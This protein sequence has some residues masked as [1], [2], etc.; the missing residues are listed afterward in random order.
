MLQDIRLYI[1]NNQVD[2]IEEIS[3]PFTYQLTDLDNPTIVKNSFSKT[4]TIE[5]TKN[6]NRIFGEIYNFDRE[7]M[8]DDVLLTGVY[9]NPSYRTPF[10]LYKDGEIIEQGYMQ[11][12]DVVIKNKT[13]QYN[14]TLYGGLGDFFYNLSYNEDN[15]PLQLKDLDY[16]QDLTFIID[17]KI[18]KKC[19]E[20]VGEDTNEITDVIQFIPC[21]NGVYDDF[22]NDKVLINTKDTDLFP[23]VKNVDDETYMVKSGYAMGE[24]N[25]EYTEWE[26]KNLVS[27]KQRPALRLKSFI[28]ACCSPVNNGGYDVELDRDFFNESNPYFNKTYIALPMLSELIESNGEVIEDKLNGG[29][30]FVGNKNG[31]ITNYGFSILRPNELDVNDFGVVNMV[32]YPINTLIDVAV[33]FQL[34]FKS[35]DNYKGILYNSG[36]YEYYQKEYYSSLLVQLE[37]VDT[38]TLE[39][40]GRSNWLNFTN[41]LLGGTFYSQPK[42]WKNWNNAN[43]MPMQTIFGEWVYSS[44]VDK[45]YFKS[46]TGNTFKIKLEKCSK[47]DNIKFQLKLEW[48]SNQNNLSPILLEKTYYNYDLSPVYNGYVALAIDS[49]TSTISI[50]SG[51]IVVAT[52]KKITQDML[53]KTEKTP[54]DYLLSY[55][56]MFGLYVYKENGENKIYIKKRNNYFNNKIVDINERIDWGNEVRINPILFDKKFYKLSLESNDSYYTEKYKTNYGVEYGQKRINTNYNFNNDTTDMLE[57]NV[58]QNVISCVDNSIYYRTFYNA[59]NKE[60][61]VFFADGYSLKLFSDENDTTID[62]PSGT[63]I[64]LDKTVDWNKKSGYDFK[65]GLCCFSKGEVKELADIESSLVFYCGKTKAKDINNNDINYWLSDDLQE[66][67]DLNESPCYLYTNTEFDSNNKWIAYKLNEIPLF[68]KY[69]IKDNTVVD[70]WDFGKPKELFIPDVNYSED[71]TIYNKYWKAMY[72]DMLNINTKLVT[73]YVNFKGMVVNNQLLKDFYYFNNSYWLLNKIENFDICSNQPVKCEFIKINDV[74]NY[75]VDLGDKYEY[76]YSS[77]N[78]I[79]LPYSKGKAKILI[80]STTKW[81]IM[82]YDN[83]IYDVYPATGDTGATL[84]TIEYKDNP[85][86]YSENQFQ[87]TLGTENN[88]NNILQINFIQ[89]PSENKTVKQYGRIRNYNNSIPDALIRIVSLNGIPYNTATIDKYTGEYSVYVPKGIEYLFEIVDDDGVILYDSYLISIEDTEFDVL[90]N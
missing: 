87:L 16:N 6:N 51:D 66:M 71:V 43:N 25:K 83:S 28:N 12:N 69:I 73:A 64:R 89:L 29:T 79:I 80:Y 26:M 40:V 38:N 68:S 31:D 88:V 24:L 57:D 65:N 7:Q 18:V 45:H 53:L 1:N 86:E 70:S 85:N 11:L 13:I 56:K 5:G 30:T 20:N 82:S 36:N 47:V 54:S 17:K 32:G 67:Y 3:L 33:D 74:Q 76:F 75:T 59:R 49:N 35:A 61:P 77:H 34:F 46:D 2:L 78:N 19:W 37:A 55:I 9:F 39:V 4:I 42:Y 48:V 63:Q 27:Y 23:V 84:I 72:E 58:F 21:Y 44:E 22:D 10:T 50:N 52:G 8:F 15:E 41:K 60:L 90:I 14:I 81:D 62:Y